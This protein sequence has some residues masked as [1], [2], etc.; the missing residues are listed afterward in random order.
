MNIRKISLLILALVAATLGIEARRA[1]SHVV[2]IG[3][4]GWGA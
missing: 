1:A 2:I 4:D 3:M